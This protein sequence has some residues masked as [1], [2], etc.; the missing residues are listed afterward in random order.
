MFAGALSLMIESGASVFAGE[1]MGFAA[2]ADNGNKRIPAAPD[3]STFDKEKRGM[4]TPL[5]KVIFG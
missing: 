3:K 4:K 5:G 2:K 1:A